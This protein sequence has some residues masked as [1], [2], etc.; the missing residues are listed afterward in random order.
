MESRLDAIIA[1]EV[2]GFNR[3]M[4]DGELAALRKLEE[5][6]AVVDPQIP[7]VRGRAFN[8]GGDNLLL[9]EERSIQAQSTFGLGSRARWMRCVSSVVVHAIDALR[10][11]AAG[12][13]WS[14]SIGRA[15]QQGG[16]CLYF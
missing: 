11:T 14:A 2:V 1:C 5:Y 7:S 12:R 8:T 3:I 13:M 15:A 16:P 6:R 4:M 9:E 10:L